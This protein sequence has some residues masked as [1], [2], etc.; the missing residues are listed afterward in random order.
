MH[1]ILHLS[2]VHFGIHEEHLVAACEQYIA[3]THADY[4]IV[5]GDLTQWNDPEEY[6]LARLWLEKIEERGHNLIVVPGNHDVPSFDLVKRFTRPV[7]DYVKHMGEYGEDLNPWI[8]DEGIAILGLNTARGLVIKNGKISNSQIELM[9]EK[10]GAASPNALRILTCH[11]PLWKLPRGEKLGDAVQNQVA[12][13]SA[14]DDCGIDL[15]LTGHNHTSSVHR[16]LDLPK[17]DGSALAIQAGTAFSTRIKIEPASFNLIEADRFNCVITVIGWDG[18]S[19]V[20]RRQHHYTRE[21]DE[22]HWQPTSA[23]AMGLVAE[24]AR[25]AEGKTKI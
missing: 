24:V 9:R 14:T 20:E 3:D 12:A 21:H 18:D 8:E 7:A 25:A 16:T 15:I 17:G 10:F 11:H 4:L 13:V 6:R 23:N 2:D 1:R 22:A 19:F 5:A